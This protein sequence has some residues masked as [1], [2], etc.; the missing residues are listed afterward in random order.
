MLEELFWGEVGG[1]L[2]FVVWVSSGF[3]EFGCF[4]L[5]QYHGVGFFED[6]KCDKGYNSNLVMVSK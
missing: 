4:S 5:E 2:G 1:E 6:E 3:S